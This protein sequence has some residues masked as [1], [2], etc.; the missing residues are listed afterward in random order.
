[1]LFIDYIGQEVKRSFAESVTNARY[2]ACL[3]DGS[4]NNSSVMEQEIMYCVP[5]IKY[6]S[7]QFAEN[8]NAE[9]VKKK[10]WG[11]ISGTT[12]NILGW[13]CTLFYHTLKL[14]LNDTLQD[15]KSFQMI[16]AGENLLSLSEFT[17]KRELKA[18]SEA[19]AEAG[20]KPSKVYGACWIDHKFGWWKFF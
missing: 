3:S 17:K 8:A 14:E 2:F 18:F 10:H 20:P 11:C 16:K 19:L 5:V 7:I 1:M 4:A 6:V 9:G 13:N 15:I 12:S